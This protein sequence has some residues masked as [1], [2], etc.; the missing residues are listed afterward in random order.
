M[1]CDVLVSSLSLLLLLIASSTG[2]HEVPDNKV[3]AAKDADADSV[4]HE[5]KASSTLDARKI[6]QQLLRAKVAEQHAAVQAL[7]AAQDAKKVKR[8]I[9]ELVKTVR[10]VISTA[11]THIDKEEFSASGTQFPTDG[12]LRESVANVVENIAFFGDLALYFPQIIDKLY[13]PDAE[14]QRLI[15]WAYNFSAKMGIYDE[16]ATKMLHLAGQQLNIIEREEDF[17]NPYSKLHM[18]EELQRAAAEELRKAQEK[19]REEKMHEQKK[20][21]RKNEPRLSKS[22]L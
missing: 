19:K 5:A 18:R 3:H 4:P 15:G 7:V 10:K 16:A 8:T 22:E 11:K 14:L 2:K 9:E 6:Y 21:K 1:A 20:K 12:A 17:V 13:Q